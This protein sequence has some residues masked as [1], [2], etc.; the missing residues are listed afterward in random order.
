MKY[1]T[2]NKYQSSTISNCQL[3]LLY[4]LLFLSICIILISK[5]LFKTV[6]PRYV[7][8]TLMAPNYKKTFRCVK[9]QPLKDL[10][11]LQEFG[12]DALFSI[13]GYKYHSDYQP[14]DHDLIHMS[15]RLLG[16]VAKPPKILPPNK[17]HYP[18]LNKTKV[19]CAIRHLRIA[20]WNIRGGLD[21]TMLGFIQTLMVKHK[22]SIL[23]LTETNY[24][25]VIKGNPY[26]C[27]ASSSVRYDAQ[28]RPHYGTAAFV[29]DPH[30]A[31]ELSL[32][33]LDDSMCSLAFQGYV[34]SGVYRKHSQD[35]LDFTNKLNKFESMPH[36]GIGDVN[37]NCYNPQPGRRDIN[38]S[39]HINECGWVCLAKD[40]SVTWRRSA[41]SY[42]ASNI[43]HIL[44]PREMESY[45][46]NGTV[47]DVDAKFSDHSL[48]YVDCHLPEQVPVILKAKYRLKAFEIE[49][50]QIDYA[51]ACQMALAESEL[52]HAAQNIKSKEDC[53]AVLLHFESKLHRI[54][55]ETIGKYSEKNFLFSNL[56]TLLQTRNLHAIE[57]K[58]MQKIFK[59]HKAANIEGW[60]DK[61]QNLSPQ[62]QLKWLKSKMIGRSRGIT[63]N[64]EVMQRNHYNQALCKPMLKHENLTAAE[65]EAEFNKYEGTLP[66]MNRTV[67]TEIISFLPL[68]KAYPSSKIPN[69]S[70]RFGGDIIIDFLQVFIQKVFQF[71]FIP[72]SFSEAFL[73]AVPKVTLPSGIEECRPISLLCV[74]RKVLDAYVNRTTNLKLPKNQ[75]G[76]RKKTSI[77]DALTHLLHNR[78]NKNNREGLCKYFLIADIAK[79]YDGL[80]RHALLPLLDL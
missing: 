16:G 32:V 48:I 31:K 21:T 12:P 60:H 67:L 13:Q 74:I 70:L 1:T 34:F 41:Y 71:G 6:T 68:R 5:Y 72:N 65:I 80:K 38:F 7:W 51:A 11:N 69:E 22:L 19:I 23:F 77:H 42:P 50:K 8:F 2:S 56:P 17:P 73:C 44:V 75:F 46:N 45:F 33:H 66:D 28:N 3:D 79:A 15:G 63:T 78:M 10:L 76:F 54:L 64:L 26:G 39:H 36:I 35:I 9:G 59:Q 4:Y 49:Q 61:I 20:S 40:S 55:N 53:E 43:D 24:D 58:D 14:Q 37:F 27:V 30:L 57:F 52:I 29:N 62:R 18:I 47:V 25:G